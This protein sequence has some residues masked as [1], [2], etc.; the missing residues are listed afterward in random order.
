[1]KSTPNDRFKLF[2]KT[3][4]L[5]IETIS[6]A[7]NVSE[8]LLKQ[9]EAERSMRPVSI[10][11]AIALEREYG[12][13]RD[14]LMHGKGELTFNQDNTDKLKDDLIATLKSQVAFYEEI[15]RKLTDKK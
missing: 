14:W 13:P 1:M 2:R 5:R 8:S 12:L 3:A 9:M 7:I 11:T 4:D 6:A 15:I 10:K